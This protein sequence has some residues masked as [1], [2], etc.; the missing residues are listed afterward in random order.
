ME[1][2]DYHI[3][4]LE[5]LTK[6]L[7]IP[8]E[9]DIEVH[10]EELE[11]DTGGGYVVHAPCD[12]TKFDVYVSNEIGLKQQLD[13][14]SHEFR[15]IWQTV[16]NIMGCTLGEEVGDHILTWEGE[17]F[18]YYDYVGRHQQQP[19]EVDANRYMKSIR[20]QMYEAIR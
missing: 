9:V 14:L 2:I 11:G 13:T 12:N 16:Y 5:F 10:F 1:K 20:L 8:I 19:H 18:S 17:P 4:A 15:H 6:D 7:E 3:R